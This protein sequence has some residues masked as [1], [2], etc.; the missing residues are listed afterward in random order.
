MAKTF[1]KVFKFE[2]SN[3]TCSKHEGIKNKHFLESEMELQSP[4]EIS[5]LLN[6]FAE[7]HDIIDVKV[8]S[9]VTD[10]HNNGRADKV[11]L[12]YTILFRESEN[13]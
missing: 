9:A 2:I 11:Y 7:R 13:E 12:Y 5:L 6:E 10:R 1:I 3:F 4:E 8:T